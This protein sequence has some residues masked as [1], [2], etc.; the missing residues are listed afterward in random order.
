MPREASVNIDDAMDF[1]LAELLLRG[2]AAT[3][4]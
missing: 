1:R 2:G 3:D 4:R